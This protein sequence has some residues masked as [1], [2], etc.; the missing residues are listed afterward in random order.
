MINAKAQQS[1]E[2]CN[3][4]GSCSNS[5]QHGCTV[6]VLLTFRFL[7]QVCHN[8]FFL[9]F[10]EFVMKFLSKIYVYYRYIYSYITGIYKPSALK[11]KVMAIFREIM[12]MVGVRVW[13][14]RG[15]VWE[16]VWNWVFVVLVLLWSRE[17]PQ[18]TLAFYFLIKA[19]SH[20]PVCV[21]TV[22]YVPNS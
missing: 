10:V 2:V 14:G 9:L 7:L 20:T 8:F 18:C 5:R 3:L 4:T 17:Y 6:I 15:R 13:A 16:E 22:G 11:I 19:N 1:R 21:S 12:E